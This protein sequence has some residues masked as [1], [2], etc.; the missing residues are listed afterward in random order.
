MAAKA[1]TRARTG[2]GLLPGFEVLFEKELL[3][4]RRSK[5]MLI[6]L[7][8]MTIGVVL[9]AVIPYYAADHTSSGM[10]HTVSEDNM[11]DIVGSW[12]ALIGYLGSLM[13]IASTVDAVSSERSL[14]ISAWIITKPVSRLSYLL[15][16]AL[17][18]SLT[19][20][21]TLVVV[22][23]AVWIA[24]MVL[25][26]ND[27]PMDRVLLA[28]VL[29]T[30]EMTFLSFVIV[31]LGVPLKSVMPIALVALGVWFIPNFVPAIG[32]IEWTAY[33]IP[34]YLPLG[35]VAASYGDWFHWFFIT[36]P[37][38]AIVIATAAFIGAVLLFERQEM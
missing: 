1:P 8:I 23:S 19:S 4:A 26:F 34:S 7:A 20:F 30:I 36:V 13:V 38:S 29:L 5:R 31:A 16:K 33:V 17:A 24:L 21:G 22:P 14:G 32:R 28:L 25:L 3:D 9:V 12:A 37:S 11:A 2:I 35:A 15:A 6:F 27:V 10:R 18:H